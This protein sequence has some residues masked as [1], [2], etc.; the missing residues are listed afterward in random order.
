MRAVV[1]ERGPEGALDALLP[2]ATRQLYD[3]GHGAIFL[4]KALEL[5]RRFPAAAAELM[6]ASTVQLSWATAET[7]LPPFAA[8]RAALARLAEM[9]L[10][11]PGGAAPGWDRAAFEAAV[12]ASEGSAVEAAL[13][14]IGEGGDPVKLLRAIAHAAA[15]RLARFDSG[16]EARLD[17][18][19]SILDVTH[20][21]TFA[22][23]AIS[24][25][26]RATPRQAAQLAVLAASFVGKLHHADAAPGTLVQPAGTGVDLA[27]AASA[28]DL[29]GA[30][31]CARDLGG[32]ARLGA[33]RELASFVA[34]DAAVRPILYAHTVKNTEA[35]RRLESE[36]PEA[37]GV[38]L[39]ALLR[40][41]VP[42]R[43]ETRA[44]RTAA[45]A[46]KFLADGRPPEGLY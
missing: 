15:V 18:E 30:L 22:E 34:F 33:Y 4:G 11:D 39:E 1:E 26:Q 29:P 16:W 3:Y 44:R 28:R 10:A 27:A 12:L 6:A 24:L 20:A 17:A 32:A 14:R 23:A 43:R 35:L 42:L 7:S 41:V 21:V 40:Y 2:F 5:S 45:V 8:T 31:A 13:A 9:K 37:D 19:V 25:A 38:Y 36:D 46:K